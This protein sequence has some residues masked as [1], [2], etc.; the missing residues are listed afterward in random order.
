MSSILQ[1]INTPD[2]WQ[3]KQKN[4]RSLHHILSLTLSA[5]NGMTLTGAKHGRLP[6]SDERGAPAS[7]SAELD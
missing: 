3:N 2:E 7:G 5:A 1:R 4:E 6:H